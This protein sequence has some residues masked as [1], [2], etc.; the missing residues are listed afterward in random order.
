MKIAKLVP[1]FKK[2]SR[3]ALENY[4]PI[5]ILPSISK[6][7][8]KIM[9]TR[10]MNH[11]KLHNAIV[12]EQ[13]GFRE[14]YSTQLAI[15]SL[16]KKI[17]HALSN[18]EFC[19]TIF[20]D[21]CKTFDSIDH[22]ILLN[23]LHHYG[24]R[25][26]A[27]EWFKSYLSGREQ[28]TEVNGCRSTV[29]PVTHGVPQGSTLGPLC[30][31]LAVNDLVH[32]SSM[33]S[34]IIFADDTNA[35]LSNK[36]LDQLIQITN[37]ELH[38]IGNWLLANKL[39]VNMSKTHLLVFKGR[40]IITRNYNIYLYNQLINEK[41]FTKFLGVYID[42]HLNWKHHIL[43][44]RNKISKVTGTITKSRDSL[45]NKSLL[46]LYYGLIYPYLQYCIVAWGAATPTT[47][48]PI[49]TIQKRAIR[50]VAGVGYRDH[51]EQLFKANN[52]L[53]F[54]DIHKLETLKFVYTQRLNPS[55]IEFRPCDSAHN[56]NLRNTHELRSSITLPTFKIKTK[57]YLVSL[58][59]HV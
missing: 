12:D 51:T 5:S 3:T 18:K 41:S 45:N 29:A 15:L 39:S 16:L 9:Y 58:Y 50:I 56:M 10:V 22:G 40:R 2:G 25:G 24:M 8:E 27:F 37:T 6:L 44:I 7:L 13:F 33:F 21:L 47:L 28:F 49:V 48:K 14:G 46:L 42:N 38:K 4:R 31:L 11:L 54:Q 19:L 53:K 52:I 43:H 59:D 35:V 1:I 32:S 34:F 55:V 20:L 23:K 57:A 30:F 26:I 36:N 17:I